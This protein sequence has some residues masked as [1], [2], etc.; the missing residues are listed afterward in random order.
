MM[1]NIVVVAV[2][3]NVAYG[4]LLN[5]FFIYNGQ[6]TKSQKEERHPVF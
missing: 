5:N 1:H 3:I 4:G 2:I 6:G